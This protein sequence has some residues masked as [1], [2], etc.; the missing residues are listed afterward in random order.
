[1]LCSGT[2][3]ASYFTEYTLVYADYQRWQRSPSLGA[4]GAPSGHWKAGITLKR[5]CVAPTAMLAS[6][7][8]YGE[9]ASIEGRSA[10]G[11]RTRLRR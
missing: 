11:G 5:P 3:P 9:E 4:M 7:I 1:M 6:S 10:R 2:D 8:R